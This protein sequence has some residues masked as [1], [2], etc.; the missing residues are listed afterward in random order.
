LSSVFKRAEIKLN[1][2]GSLG[3]LTLRITDNQQSAFSGMVAL[4]TSTMTIPPTGWVQVTYDD[5]DR[6]ID[7]M[8]VRA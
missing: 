6:E 4:A 8:E 5:D 2:G 7:D 3:V 1:T